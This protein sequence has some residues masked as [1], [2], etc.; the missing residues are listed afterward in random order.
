[1]TMRPDTHHTART[2]AARKERTN[3]L[4][5]KIKPEPERAEAQDAPAQS[6]SSVD[7]SLTNS[8]AARNGAEQS[9]READRKLAMAGATGVGG[10]DT[11]TYDQAVAIQRMAQVA[12]Q[13]HDY[14]A[15]QAL[16]NKAGRLAA[17]IKPR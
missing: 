2:E 8:Y 17:A 7:I 3:G 16:G 14:A 5:L 13:K 9:L 6:K 12:M 15:A 10:K 4:V 1:M 11:R